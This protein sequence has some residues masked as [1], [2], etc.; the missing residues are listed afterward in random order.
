LSLVA[1]DLTVARGGR[2]LVEGLSFALPPGG[3]LLVTGPNGAGKSSLLRVLAGLARPAGGT[4]ERP[5]RVAL[6][7]EQAALDPERTLGAA[8]DFWG[9][10]DGGGD[11][12][13]ALAAVGLGELADVPVRFLSTGQRRRAALARVVMAGAALWLLDE[14][15]TGLDVGAVTTLE[16]LMAAH[17]AGGGMAVV[18]THQPLTLPGAVEV[19]L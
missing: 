9:R 13:A 2:R 5:E 6:L 16:A 17:R 8:L 4:I 7:A 3:A 11:V 15:A 19:R 1:R 18:A 14:P 10:V 12:T